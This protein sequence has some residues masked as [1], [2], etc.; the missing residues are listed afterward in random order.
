MSDAIGSIVGAVGNYITAK[1]TSDANQ[2]INKKNIAW[3]A[4]SQVQNQGWQ[5]YMRSTAYQATMADMKK[6]GL[7]P[8]LAFS[9]GPTSWGS[10]GAAPGSS[11]GAVAPD[12]A[13]GLERGVRAMTSARAAPLERAILTE[14]AEN[15]RATREQTEANTRQVNLQTALLP[16]LTAA[17][18]AAGHGTGAAGQ[19]S[20]ELSRT[21]AGVIQR[22]GPSGPFWNP[23]VWGDLGRRAA[24]W[25]GGILSS[26]VE[27]N[28][29]LGPL[30]NPRTPPTPNSGRSV[31]EQG[32]TIGPD[33]PRR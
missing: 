23:Q 15:L 33:A 16:G 17:Q 2:A 27:A 13:G 22:S 11:L 20:G 21:Q 7:N 5:E 25:L 10:A 4:Q 9:R 29:A 14:Q 1:E 8:M 19:G 6:A 28:R 12:I 24:S 3:Q 31:R 32:F 30:G 26:A 18:V